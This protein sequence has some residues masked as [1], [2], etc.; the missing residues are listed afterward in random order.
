MGLSRTAIDI[1]ANNP[2]SGNTDMRS[3]ILQC[4]ELRLRN[5]AL[6][7]NN[8]ELKQQLQHER[9]S[10]QDVIDTMKHDMDTMKKTTTE[11]EDQ[12]NL[13]I[14]ITELDTR[15]EVAT[16]DSDPKSSA[17]S[18]AERHRVLCS[19]WKKKCRNLKD[20]YDCDNKSVDLR[21]SIGQSFKRITRAPSIRSNTIKPSQLHRR[22]PSDDTY[23]TADCTFDASS[24]GTS[25]CVEKSG[26]FTTCVSSYQASEQFVV[27]SLPW[28]CEHSH[29]DG[30]Y[31]GQMECKSKLPDG[32]G[33]FR[34]ENGNEKICIKGVWKKGKLIRVLDNGGMVTYSHGEISSDNVSVTEL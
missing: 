31:F 8:N 13:L 22:T 27:E 26:A 7:K 2:S 23:S 25:L 33:E 30:L 19:T 5:E 15:D 6:E 16:L 28:K 14:R 20:R 12:V 4:Q 34:Y 10:F 9:T 21:V 1:N 17:H 24:S 11:L 18:E 29:L 3:L 32:L